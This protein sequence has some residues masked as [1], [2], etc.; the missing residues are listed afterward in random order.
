MTTKTDA[1]RSIPA[2]T[3]PS[4]R[5]LMIMLS[6]TTVVMAAQDE[7]LFQRQLSTHELP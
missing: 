6:K 7:S 2:D 3:Q 5:L 1:T 4:R